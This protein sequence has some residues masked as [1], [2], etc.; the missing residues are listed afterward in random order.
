[1]AVNRMKRLH[2]VAHN[3][4]RA[5]L[6]KFLQDY[7]KSVLEK[8]PLERKDIRKEWQKG[9]ITREIKKIYK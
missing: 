7:K 4:H 2:I 5:E 1:M 8:G 9:K 6:I 3:S